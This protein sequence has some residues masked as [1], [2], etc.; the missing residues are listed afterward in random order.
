MSETTRRNVLAGAAGVGAAAVLAACGSNS[1]DTGST[2]GSN[3][4]G[5][6]AAPTAGQQP[7]GSGAL[8]K[9]SEIPVGGGK[10]LAEQGVVVTQ[11]VAGEFKAFSAK[12]TH[13]GC[14]VG[15]V[16]GGT[17]ICPC[18]N[19]KFSAT[20]GSVKG[21]PASSALAAKNVTVQGDDIVLA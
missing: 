7:A 3:N 19:S 9:K 18:H 2:G 15:S 21:G 5:W 8:A 1:S 6:Q 4:N 16:A 10:V 20:D 11:P 13:A 14:L 17:I 12:C